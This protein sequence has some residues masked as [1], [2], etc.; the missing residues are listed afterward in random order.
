M[1]DRSIY[2]AEI[3]VSENKIES[4]RKTS[5]NYSRF[6]L[7]PLVDSHIHIESSMLTPSGFAG[8]AV[9]HGT[10]AVVSDPHEIANVVGV[11]GV[12]FMIKNGNSVPLKFFFGVPSCVPATEFESA[13]GRIESGEVGELLK[14]D[15]IYF[16]SEM[17]NFP[18]VLQNDSQI[19][20]KI[21]Y[22][23]KYKKPVDG[24]A[25]G[26]TGKELTRYVKAGIST[27][28]EIV[29]LQEAE[30]KIAQGMIIQIREGSAAKSFD[31][32]SELIDRFPEMVM[33][34]SDDLHPDDLIEGH[35]NKLLARGV[36]K[37]CDIFNLIRSAS[38]NP[39]IHYNLPVGMLREN[40]FADFVVL[41]DLD[42]FEVLETYINGERAFG[43]GEVL[44]E[45]MPV[46]LNKRFRE[47]H[48][49][50]GELVIPAT[51]SDILVIQARDGELNTG[52]LVMPATIIDG[53]AVSD[54][55]R[56]LCKIV[57]VNRYEN[58]EPVAGFITGFGLKEGSIAGSVAHDSHN[59]IAIGVNDDDISSA[60]NLVMEMGGGLAA[61]SGH[62]KMKLQLEIGGLMTAR[63]G[64]DVAR[65]YKEIDR[66]AKRLG[67]TLHAP[68]MSMSFMAL[69]V[70]PELK[71]G[72]KGLFNVNN[73]SFTPLFVK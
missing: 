62:E 39:V 72:D 43:G 20:Q 26:L 57:V 32:F 8:L 34:C 35:I 10:V 5:G 48:I 70:I 67:S 4:I 25:P 9:R 33:L 45:I 55:Q 73:F 51:G 31:L 64:Y 6:I 18:G 52:S 21:E 46:K 69:L 24:H 30:E 16:L 58:K 49:T 14:R 54:I 29:T 11:E 53:Y 44:F 23:R 2:P 50:S 1:F 40:D 65:E 42:N 56:D 66:F 22:A 13:G 59:I 19:M 63:D 61:V 38:I 17:M 27:D 60:V 15:D 7:P 12:D 47:Q 68:F 37:G 36:K 71:I 28:H 3:T 41:K